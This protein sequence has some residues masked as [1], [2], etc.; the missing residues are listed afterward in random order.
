[1]CGIAGIVG[2]GS[3]DLIKEMCEVQAHR[4]P[5]DWGY[6]L[7][8]GVFL[9]HRRLSVID[10]SSRGR[11]PLS[12]EDGSVQLV[13]NGEIYNF[14]EL[15]ERLEKR[16]H[17]F[18]SDTDSEVIIHAYEDKGE[19]CLGELKGAFAFALWDSNKR[20]MFLVRDRI[21][22]KPL[23]YFYDGA[24]LIF[25]SEIKA[26]LRCGVPRR[27]NLDSL[28]LYLA[29]SYVPSPLTMFQDI[30]KL[31]P[32]HYIVFRDSQLTYK[33]YWDITD[34]RDIRG[35]E[36]S[37]K[38][39]TRERLRRAVKAQ[40]VSD[41]PL[42]IFLSGGVDSS[43]ILSMFRQFD[44][45]PIKTFSLGFDVEIE[46]EKFNID[47]NLARTTSRLFGT[48]HHEIV[49]TA[50]DV[51]NNFEKLVYHLDEPIS[52]STQAAQFM[53]SQIA[54]Q[55]VA[56]VLAGEG[57][58][59]TFGGYTE[60][61]QN[62]LISFYQ[63]LP[64]VIR[65]GVIGPL[66]NALLP[67][68]RTQNRI[69][70]TP[71]SVDRYLLFRSEDKDKIRHIMDSECYREGLEKEFIHSHYFNKDEIPLN[72][73]LMYTDLK[74]KLADNFLLGADKM[75]MA[76]GL[77]QRSPFL[78]HKLVEFAFKIPVK[79][80]VRRRE[81]KYILKRAM[82]GMIP[83]EVLQGK[84]YFF[85]PAA[86]WM[87]AGL[88]PMFEDYLSVSSLQRS[89]FFNVDAVREMLENHLTLKEYNLG[90]LWAVFTFQVWHKQFIE[91]F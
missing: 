38:E 42:G 19:E 26:I 7:G 31:P 2:Q 58:D 57:G 20:K 50:E 30:S 55:D 73:R 37:I 10:L 77:E 27:V 65:S 45:S 49:L 34:F 82:S 36:S 70:N 75:T 63:F 35:N 23:Y 8:E 11:Q 67:R 43:A 33:E 72:K 39:E 44:G 3:E 14:R 29:L 84:R 5:D 71:G 68:Y 87:R 56:V 83:P 47:F 22:E 15:R 52:N 16:G 79:L 76:F 74:T 25:A 86:K 1:M 17:K 53:L 69:L 78:D 60:Y 89:G 28:N 21:G 62:Q 24:R 13:C 54:K 59:E 61:W 81:T 88:K 85:P 32:A 12:N 91:N 90:L 4:G 9:G 80:K 40:T 48:D 6:Y 41:R 46:R 51:L 18:H 64:P 66:V